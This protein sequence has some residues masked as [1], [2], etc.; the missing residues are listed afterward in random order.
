[1]H[2][3]T[4]T[5]LVAS[6]AMFCSSASQAE[7]QIQ[8]V[9]VGTIGHVDHGKTTLTVD[10]Q[11]QS[12]EPM[13]TISYFW[14]D[15]AVSGEQ[16]ELVADDWVTEAGMFAIANDDVQSDVTAI[17]CASLLEDTGFEVDFSWQTMTS[18][19]LVLP[20]LLAA[21]SLLTIENLRVA[22]EPDLNNDGSA[23]IADFI[24]GFQSEW[25]TPGNGINA[26]EGSASLTI[27]APGSLALLAGGLMGV[28]RRRVG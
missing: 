8:L 5:C 22:F 16:L 3:T 1:M 12:S 2:L 20:D 14:F 9:N 7:F 17:G 13:S 26:L 28:R 24:L 10:L 25:D 15:A 19:S 23:D 6:L 11:V 4:P 18:L 27:P 21:D